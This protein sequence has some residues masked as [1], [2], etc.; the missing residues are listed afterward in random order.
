MQTVAAVF[1]RKK[2]IPNILSISQGK[3]GKK[4]FGLSL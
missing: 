3:T 4:P 1:F 2:V